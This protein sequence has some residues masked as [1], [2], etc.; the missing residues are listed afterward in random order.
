MG[1]R[2]KCAG[3]CCIIAGLV[4]FLFSL[5]CQALFAVIAFALIAGGLFLLCSCR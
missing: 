5:P 1:G 2:N 4:L 3:I